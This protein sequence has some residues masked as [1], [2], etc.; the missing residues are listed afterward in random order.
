AELWG[1]L[2][3][4]V[5]LRTDG[6]VRLDEGFAAVG[7]FVSDQNDGWIMGFYRYLGNCTVLEAE[8]WGILDGLNFILDRSFKRVLI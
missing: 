1:I 3:G 8:L 6:L 4:W 2:D 7:D 5:R